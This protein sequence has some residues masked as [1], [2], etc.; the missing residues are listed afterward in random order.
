M[1]ILANLT[2]ADRDNR[3]ETL[4]DRYYALLNDSVIVAGHLAADSG[5]IA[6]AK[7]ELQNKITQRLLNIDKTMQKHK[8]LV[9]AYAIDGLNEYYNE[10]E[11]KKTILQF[12]REQLTSSSPKTR[13]KAKQF[14]RKW[15][16]YP[17]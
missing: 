15:S 10:A 3:F 13:T 5:T 7:P 11:N 1:R 14:L 9:K 4:F 17:L 8:G 16:Q 12:V 2:Q 6:K